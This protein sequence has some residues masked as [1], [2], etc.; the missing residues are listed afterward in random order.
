MRIGYS[1][2]LRTWRGGTAT[3]DLAV[4]RPRRCCQRGNRYTFPQAQRPSSDGVTPASTTPHLTPEQAQQGSVGDKTEPLNL[5][6]ETGQRRGIIVP[7]NAQRRRGAPEGGFRFLWPSRQPRQPRQRR[8]SSLLFTPHV[9]WATRLLNV[10]PQSSEPGASA[11]TTAA[12]MPTADK[13]HYLRLARWGR[14]TKQSPLRKRMLFAGLPFNASQIRKYLARLNGASTKWWPNRHWAMALHL[15]AR[16]HPLRRRPQPPRA[17][18]PR[19]TQE[20]NPLGRQVGPRGAPDRSSLLF[21]LFDKSRPTVIL[22]VVSAR[23]SSRPANHLSS[24][25]STACDTGRA[26]LTNRMNFLAQR[27][28]QHANDPELEGRQRRLTE[29]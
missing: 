3:G 7:T 10:A 29:S 19:D 14:Q 26:N 4:C 6:G 15:L 17:Q 9:P 20:R 16:H 12:V 28:L 1:R 13:A 21:R 23:P 5:G 2:R 18:P 25:Q 24:T 27:P 22:S 11:K 8:G